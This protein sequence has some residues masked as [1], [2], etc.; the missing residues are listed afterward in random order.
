MSRSPESA[1]IRNCMFTRLYL[2]FMTA[3]LTL[4]LHTYSIV[5]NAPGKLLVDSG[6]F[7]RDVDQFDHLEFGITAKDAQLMPLSTRK[8][9]E[10]S[11]LALQDAGVHFR[12]KNVGCYMSGVAHD[13]FMISGHV[14]CING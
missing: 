3:S 6:T 1:S 7:L 8:L 13:L 11:F 4:R 10:L 12:G 2:V 14:S 9:V 5:G